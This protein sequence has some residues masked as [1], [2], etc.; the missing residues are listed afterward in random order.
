[1]SLKWVKDRT[2]NFKLKT[3]LKGGGKEN[4]EGGI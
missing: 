2:T 3:K 1:M 4:W